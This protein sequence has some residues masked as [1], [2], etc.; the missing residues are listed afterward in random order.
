[1]PIHVSRVHG[2]RPRAHQADVVA[3]A[4]GVGDDGGVGAGVGNGVSTPRDG[5]QGG[6]GLDRMDRRAG[7]LGSVE[8]PALRGH[9]QQGSAEP[10]FPKP[11]RQTTEVVLHQ[12][13][14][15]GVDARRGGAPVLAQRWVDLVGKS[16]GDV[17]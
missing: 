9:R 13:L 6:T 12:Y 11:S 16:V 3:S 17:G 2:M 4:P 7:H 1:M 14:E 8:H 10:R 15:G 5:R